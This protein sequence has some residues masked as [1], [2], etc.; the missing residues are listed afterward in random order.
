MMADQKKTIKIGP[1]VFKVVLVEDLKDDKGETMCG[2]LI[3]AKSEIIINSDSDEFSRR[4][5]LW[6]EILH[7]LFEQA[8]IKHDEKI[9]DTLA[10]GIIQVLDDNEGKV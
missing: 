2:R 4:Q 3:F 1:Q 6:H 8:S 10:Y 7:G 9:I 5:T